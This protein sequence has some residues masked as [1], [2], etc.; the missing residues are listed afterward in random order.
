MDLISHAVC[1]SFE[2]HH[3]VYCGSYG[4][5][6][7]SLKSQWVQGRSSGQQKRINISFSRASLYLGGGPPINPLSTW[8]QQG[9]GRKRFKESDYAPW[10][11]HFLSPWSI[12]FLS[13]SQFQFNQHHVL[14]EGDL[15]YLLLHYL[16]ISRFT[17]AY[18][19]FYYVLCTHCHFILH[20]N[21]IYLYYYWDVTNLHMQVCP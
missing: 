8:S 21:F 4:F 9:G 12:H 1:R 18:V 6:A 3:H 14:H 13:F 11:I 20:S 7:G 2:N 5:S 17:Y 10:S 19:M 16:T 15:C